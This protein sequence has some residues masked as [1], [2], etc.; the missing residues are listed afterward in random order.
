MDI[1]LNSFNVVNEIKYTEF[2]LDP[3]KPEFYDE[4]KFDKNLKMLEKDLNLEIKSDKYFENAH[5]LVKLSISIIQLEIAFNVGLWGKLITLIVGNIVKTF[6][7]IGADN[8]EYKQAKLINKD[9]KYSPED[10]ANMLI[11]EMSKAYES[12]D[13][14]KAM[15]SSDKKKAKDILD[16]NMAKLLEMF[17]EKQAEFIRNRTPGLSGVLDALH[18]NKQ[19]YK[20]GAQAIKNH[21]ARKKKV[22]ESFSYLMK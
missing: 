7:R 20:A 4:D 14:N 1:N 17:D 13:K 21:K 15:S 18:N 19:A 12:I 2:S 9:T 5:A 8:L 11:S 6:M 3:S 10:H 22:N 16:K